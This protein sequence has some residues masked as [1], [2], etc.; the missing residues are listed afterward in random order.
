MAKVTKAIIGAAIQGFEAQKKDIDGQIA[1]LRAMMTGAPVTPADNE[2]VPA[3]SGG[4][5]K[6]R[7][8][9]AAFRARMKA[10]QQ[11]RSAKVKGTAPVLAAPA[12]KTAAKA[13]AKT[14]A[15]VR[16]PAK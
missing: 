10:A 11:L 4:R 12:A 3:K 5:L 1:E 8:L 6:G 2:A 14:P 7:K 15:K 9:S 16:I 13:S